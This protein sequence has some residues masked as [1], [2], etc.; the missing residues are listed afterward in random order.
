MQPTP[1]AISPVSVQP[2]R[3]IRHPL[4]AQA[5]AVSAPAARQR[6]L[7]PWS[8]ADPDRLVV[9]SCLASFLVMPFLL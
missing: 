7:A 9:L 3:G 4:V 5:C 1:R 6:S 2:L 8:G